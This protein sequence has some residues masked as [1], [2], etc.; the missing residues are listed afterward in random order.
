MSENSRV[1][2]DTMGEVKVPVYAYWGAQT[3]RSRDNFK[4][5]PVATMP[6]EVIYGF[7]YLKKAA[8]HANY[9]LK[10]LSEEKKNLISQV[11]Q[12]Q[13][14]YLMQKTTCL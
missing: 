8:A 7:A 10:V 9:D 13:K 1:E 11:F 5:G 4:I 3:Q 6:L 2:R 12:I 14:N